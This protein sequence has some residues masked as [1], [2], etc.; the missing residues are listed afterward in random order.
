[1]LVVLGCQHRFADAPKASLTLFLDIFADGS[2][3]TRERSVPYTPD[4]G[5]TL[6]ENRDCIPASLMIERAIELVDFPDTTTDPTNSLLNAT[7][8]AGIEIMFLHGS[9]RSSHETRKTSLPLLKFG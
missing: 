2:I 9:R 7:G 5:V 3:R 6:G 4:D 8:R 1:M